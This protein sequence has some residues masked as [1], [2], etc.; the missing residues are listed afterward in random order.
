MN[1]KIQ[2][3]KTPAFSG[4]C[5]LGTFFMLLL[6]MSCSSVK[7]ITHKDLTSRHENN[8]TVAAFVQYVNAN[9]DKVPDH[10]YISSALVKM[11]DA[12]TAMAGEIDYPLAIDLNKAKDYATKIIQD[13]NE[14]TH[15]DNIRKAADIETAALKNMRLAHYHSL[16]V[17]VSDLQNDAE[18]INPGV[19]VHNQKEAIKTFL[20][21]AAGV[22][23][24]MN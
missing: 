23:D 2:E 19:L 21:N 9:N 6:L 18:A 1:K 7:R 8:T 4:L 10:A 14:T 17:Q 3:G 22:L 5:G 12:I 13:R 16:S 20:K 15:A 24:E 11:A